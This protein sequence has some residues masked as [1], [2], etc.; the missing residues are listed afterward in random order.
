MKITR[1][2]SHQFECHYDAGVLDRAAG[3]AAPNERSRHARPR[4]NQALAYPIGSGLSPE[5]WVATAQTDEPGL[6]IEPRVERADDSRDAAARRRRPSDRAPGGSV[7]ARLPPRPGSWTRRPPR[8]RSAPGGCPR[9]GTR[10]DG[11]ARALRE[12]RDQQSGS[13]T[14]EEDIVTRPRAEPAHGI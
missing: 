2:C 3:Q 13:R 7:R 10:S 12:S 14:R 1:V 8:D 6:E 9:Q 11:I 4:P 5:E